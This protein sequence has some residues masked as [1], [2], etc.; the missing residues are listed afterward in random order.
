MQLLNIRIEK[1]S[2][3]CSLNY[4]SVVIIFPI[5]FLLSV[6]YFIFNIYLTSVSGPILKLE[7]ARANNW[8]YNPKEDYR[9][10]E[11]LSENYGE[12]FGKVFGKKSVKD[13]FWGTIMKGSKKHFFYTGTYYYSKFG[14][15]KDKDFNTE[16]FIGVRLNKT[17]NSRFYLHPETTYDRIGNMFTNKELNTESIEFNK[18]FAFSY[19]GEKSEEGLNIIQTLSPAVQQ[20]LIDLKK[21]TGSIRILF[22]EDSVFFSFKEVID[23]FYDFDLLEDIEIPKKS[24]EEL[25]NKIKTLIDISTDIAKY[26]N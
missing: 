19:N 16:T 17:I 5:V 1:I 23:D 3:L 7:I 20:K 21:M 6:P 25:E 10:Y 22:S 14:G 4:F 13:Q 11:E 9:S 26:L 2:K 24:K 18:H 15:D 8:L 12:I